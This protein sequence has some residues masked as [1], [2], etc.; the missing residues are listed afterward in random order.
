M[1]AF[2]VVVFLVLY[3]GASASSSRSDQGARELRD[4]GRG[5]GGV[6]LVPHR[7]RGQGPAEGP[8]HAALPDPLGA[9]L[10][11]S[12][13]T[14]I[15]VE[16]L[17][18]EHWSE[19]AEAPWSEAERAVALL[20]VEI[21]QAQLGRQARYLPLLLQN[22]ATFPRH[23]EAENLL[24]SVHFPYYERSKSKKFSR[25]SREISVRGVLAYHT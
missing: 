12:A 2:R 25:A 22:N 23:F 20:F 14:R 21:L 3:A 11:D 13:E 17:R 4:D 8:G 24:T 18:P 19:V 1:R 6:P 10:R 9:P 7:R 16:H 15:V 5:P